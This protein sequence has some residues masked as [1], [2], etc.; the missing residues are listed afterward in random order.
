MVPLGNQADSIGIWGRQIERRQ[1]PGRVIETEAELTD[2]TRPRRLVI[3]RSS[4]P[5]RPEAIYE[6]TPTATGTLIDFHVRV[7]LEGVTTLLTPLVWLLLMLVVG[8]A[9]PG[10]FGRLKS[11]LERGGAP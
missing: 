4:G 7:Q 9:L 6:L 5:I 3:Q 11:L 2:R 10:D 8:P 1:V